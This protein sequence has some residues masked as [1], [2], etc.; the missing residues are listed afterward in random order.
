MRPLLTRDDGFTLIELLVVLVTI[1][2]LAGTAIAQVAWARSRGYDAQVAAVVRGIATGQEAYF[3]S[4][5][6]YTSDPTDLDV[7]V[8]DVTVAISAGNSGDLASSFRVEGFHA[9][10]SQRFAWVS[11]PPPGASHLESY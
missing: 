4:H 3:A 7:A 6:R 8:G 1:V 10:A 5:I 2:V 11:D 9:G